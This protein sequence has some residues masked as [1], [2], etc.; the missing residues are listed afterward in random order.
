MKA[1]IKI[2][3]FRIVFYITLAAVTLLAFLPNY[4]ALPP[5][6]SFSDLLNHTVAFAVLYVLFTQAHPSLLTKH[7]VFALLFYAVL[8][9]AVQYFLPTR[10][11]SG[12]DIIADAAGVLTGYL[13]LFQ[14][15]RFLYTKDLFS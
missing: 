8:I 4:D 9:E 6:V 15:K 1:S 14:L 13:I 5:I 12:S 7:T 3:L 10:Y 11:A 2:Y